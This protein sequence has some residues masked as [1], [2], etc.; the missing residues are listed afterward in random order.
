MI[1]EKFKEEHC[2]TCL[3]KKECNETLRRRIDGNIVCNKEKQKVV[4]VFTK[5]IVIGD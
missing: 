3:N 1:F 5:A 2:K 4:G